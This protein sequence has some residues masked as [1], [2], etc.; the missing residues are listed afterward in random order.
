[1]AAKVLLAATTAWPSA[2]RLAQ[3]FAKLG[4]VAEIVAP[5][6]APARKSRFIDATYA[7]SPF[8]PL[9]A[10][11]R[12]I[13]MS[14][15]ELIVP[16]DDRAVR[17][18]LALHARAK[19]TGKRD[20]AALIGRSLGIPEAYGTLF[21]RAAFIAEAEALGVAVPRTCGIV[22]ERELEDALSALGLPAVLKSDGSWGG[23]GVAIVRTREEAHAAFRRM[24]RPLSRLRAAARAFNRGDAHYLAEALCPVR[25][26]LS[27]Q[28]FI[29]GTPAT[30]AF[31]SWQGDVLAAI[32][33]DVA[34]SQGGTGPASVVRQIDNPAMKSAARKLARRFGL[35]GL[36]G[37]DFIRNA[38]GAVYL[39]EINPRA[40]QTAALALGEGRDLLAALAARAGGTALSAR[41]LA[42]SADLIALFP[43]EWLRDPASP[44]LATAHHDVPWDDPAVLRSCMPVRTRPKPKMWLMQR[45]AV[46]RLSPAL[47]PLFRVHSG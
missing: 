41:P 13:A 20:V 10:M 43:Q 42:A 38:K 26:V 22:S 4:C 1:M 21:S 37:L 5:A 46:F 17:L 31:A 27:L 34:V 11:S 40:T 3:G 25:P 35:S 24:S 6:N 47:R 36:H 44:Y 9:R 14:G 45:R 33:M 12:A 39:L 8:A 2:A 32:Y 18:L 7:Y 29:P 15:A 23:D 19:E 28:E 30:T 16:C